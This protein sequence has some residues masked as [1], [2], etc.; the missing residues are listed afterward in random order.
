MDISLRIKK[1]RNEKKI[2]SG[3]FADLIKVDRSQYSKLESGKLTPTV[4][5][6]MEI[7][8]IFNVSTDW[9]LTGK[10]PQI[11]VEQSLIKEDAF[12]GGSPF[13]ED[14][15]VSAGKTDIIS[16]NEQPTGY[17]KIPGV[18]A[19]AYFPVIGC[20][21]E[22]KINAGDIV[23]VN[24]IDKWDKIDPDKLYMI[25]THEDRMIKHLR[26]DIS[27]DD[28]LWGI[29]ANEKEF[30]IYKGDIKIIYHIVFCGRLI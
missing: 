22:P 13:Y 9:L 30:P 11:T 15:P 3:A 10:E 5:Q 2:G 20:C 27:R 12:K 19:L 28:I 23:G 8:S 7:S 25:I 1:L 14:L 6:I 4:L 18:N 24:N 17:L 21:F 16:S 26:I 29:S